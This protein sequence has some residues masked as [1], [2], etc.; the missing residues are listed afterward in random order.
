MNNRLNL[1]QQRAQDAW[2]CVEEAQKEPKISYDKYVNSAKGMPVLIMNSG[3]MQMLAF[4]EDKQKEQ[5]LIAKQLR[6]W[7]KSRFPKI[8]SEDFGKFMEYL[9]KD[10]EPQEY[11]AI[12]AEAFAWLRWIRQLAA[13]KSGEK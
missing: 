3:L 2:K 11:Q 4:A 5:G 13:A 8:V 1:E 10:S 6:K 9:M 12:T 7:L